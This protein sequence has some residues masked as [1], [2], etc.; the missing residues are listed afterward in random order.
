MNLTGETS[1]SPPLERVLKSD[2]FI[3]IGSLVFVCLVSW[4]YILS[5]AGV[6][7]GEMVSVKSSWTPAY[8]ALMLTMWWVMMVAMM[9]PSAAPTILLFAA[10][11]RKSHQQ[12]RPYTQTGFFAAGYLA[13]WGGFS[14][15]A[16]VAQWGL[17]HLTLLSTMMQT[18]SPYLGAGLLIAAGAYQLTPLKQAC[19]RHCRSPIEFIAHHWRQGTVGAFRM[20]LEHGLFC[21][22]C[23]WVLMALLYY[24]G[25]MNL[26]WIA[27]LA[28]YV[29]IEKLSPLG[30]RFG[31]FTGSF[32][33]IWGV[34]VLLEAA[35]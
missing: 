24:G 30:P 5:G 31:R 27:G 35:G 4:F 12:G 6:G 17:V 29:L 9:L 7:M 22:G 33:I 23:C 8:F 21:L 20:G 26:W 1:Q 2:R 28:F 18:T 11:N 16:V 15:V 25:V 3:T 19:L 13:V 10:V 32:L 14:F 34:G